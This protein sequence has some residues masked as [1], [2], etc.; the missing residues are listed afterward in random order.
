MPCCPLGTTYTPREVAEVGCQHGQLAQRSTTHRPP[1]GP[2]P[3]TAL[4]IVGSHK[5][6]A[7]SASSSGRVGDA[8]R[9]HTAE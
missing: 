5:P 2:G 9:R 1:A 3:V 8:L 6:A 4:S 7:R